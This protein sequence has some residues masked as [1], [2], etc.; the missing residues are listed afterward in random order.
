MLYMVSLCLTHNAFGSSNQSHDVPMG[1]FL[2]Y[3]VELKRGSGVLCLN[4]S[5]NGS[6]DH[7]G[8]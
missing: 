8:T 3:R 2:I 6:T 4:S 7:A 5:Q 1:V